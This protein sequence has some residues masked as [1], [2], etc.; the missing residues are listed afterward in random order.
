MLAP[1][2]LMLAMAIAGADDPSTQPKIT[3][4]TREEVKEALERLKSRKPRLPLAEPTEEEIARNKEASAGNRSGL[5][6]GLVNNARMRAQ[7]L[8]RELQTAGGFSRE[9]DPKMSLK[10]PFPTEL[11][12]IV[13]R[14]NN[15]HY[16][17]GHQES[18]LAADG[19]SD[20]QIAA[21][22]GDWHEFSS[23]ERA[24]F[25][26]TR[27]LTFEPHLIGSD[28]IA[29]LREEFP[30]PQA[31]EIVFLVSRYNSTNR[32]TDGLGIPQETHRVYKTLV[33]DKYRSLVSSVAPL[34]PAR[35]PGTS[36]PARMA[37]RGA[38]E[39]RE[40][41][42]SRLADAR[43]RQSRFTLVDESQTREL[44]PD[45]PAGTIPQYVRL[46]SQFPKTGVSAA[47][48]IRLLESKGLVSP[49]LRTQIAWI[50]ARHD[51][52]W[53]A[54]GR[55]MSRLKTL[56]ATDDEIFALDAL[57]GRFA[58]NELPVLKLARKLTIAPQLIN[59]ADIE[60]VREHYSD[61]EVA[62]IVHRITHAAFFDRLTEAAGLQLEE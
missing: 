52:A 38:L 42:V 61:S 56:G 26:F 27:K 5:G 33:S 8:P 62:E 24:A 17:L 25:A 19:L 40:Q 20:D 11:F 13:S 53:Y 39:S 3:P 58:A 36:S 46:L 1:R 22:D 35:A 34:D 12:W 7:H 59:D 14:V 32:W 45:L 49:L 2:V 47:Q 31:L 41:V 37:P 18:K 48:G 55:A 30:E 28:D 21:L 60:S 44:V 16:C 50:A 54:L 29:R 15:C 43:R 6:A 23:P 51:R 10:A 4:A 9:P 57:D